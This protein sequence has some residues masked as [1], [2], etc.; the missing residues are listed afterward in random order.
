[1]A[2]TP[3]LHYPRIIL[4]LTILAQ[5]LLKKGMQEYYDLQVHG[6]QKNLEPLVSTKLPSIVE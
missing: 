5:E 4:D 1:M 3:P 2:F 6:K